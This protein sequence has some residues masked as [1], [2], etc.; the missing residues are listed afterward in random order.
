ME[1]E[2]ILGDKAGERKAY[3]A[4]VQKCQCDKCHIINRINKELSA[5]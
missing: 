4:D 5:R 2:E 3:P 1:A